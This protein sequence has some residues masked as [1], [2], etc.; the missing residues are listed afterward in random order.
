MRERWKVG[1]WG[2]W[3]KTW[4]H[5]LTK[6]WSPSTQVLGWQY[7][8]WRMSQRVC[9]TLQS[10]SPTGRRRR[11]TESER[12]Y[13]TNDSRIFET[14]SSRILFVSYLLSISE[15]FVQKQ[16]GQDPK[17]GDLTMGRVKFREIG[18]EARTRMLC[19]TLGWPVV[20]GEIPIELGDSWFSSK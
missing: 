12:A 2:R 6:N 5:T 18:M 4:N 11:E 20:R 14:N 7:S 1:R 10:L 15:P 16:R 3:N 17:P 9:S 8:Y 13:R 19:K